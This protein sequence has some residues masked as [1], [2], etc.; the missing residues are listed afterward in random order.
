MFIKVI[1][2][3]HQVIVEEAISDTQYCF[4]HNHG[5]NDLIF[6]TH[7]LIEKAVEHDTKVFF[8]VHLQKAYDSVTRAAM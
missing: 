8:F 5:C 2:H 1:Q 7:Q 4:Q 6:C 3:H